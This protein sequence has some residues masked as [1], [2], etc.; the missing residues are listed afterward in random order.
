ME[1]MES[2]IEKTTIESAA[3][4]TDLLLFRTCP[5][6]ASLLPF[7]VS[8]LKHLCSGSG[9]RERQVSNI[10]ATDSPVLSPGR[11]CTFFR[12]DVYWALKTVEAAAH[13]AAVRAS[14]T[15]LDVYRVRA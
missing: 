15:R 3:M 11:S 5:L 7:L 4:V 9:N 2:T 12:S 1:A 10:F 13:R 14:V 8:T 6:V